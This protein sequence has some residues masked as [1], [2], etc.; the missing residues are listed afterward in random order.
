MKSLEILHEIGFSG[1]FY[2][3]ACSDALRIYDEVKREDYLSIES[4]ENAKS[5]IMVGKSASYSHL[6]MILSGMLHS[7]D[8]YLDSGI[9]EEIYLDTMSD[10]FIWAELYRRLEGKV[11]LRETGWLLLHI[12]L[13]LFRL[14][15]LQ[16]Q[17][18]DTPEEFRK[19]VKSD[20]VIQVHIPDIGP[21][22]RDECISSFRKAREFYQGNL[23]F[24]C[25]SWLLDPEL[26]R[27]LPENSN[28]LEFQRLFTI[29]YVDKSNP[30]CHQRVFEF[31]DKKDTSLQRNILRE[32]ALGTVFGV[33]YGYFLSDG[34]I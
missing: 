22:D 11:G 32:E 23:P 19:E 1:A 8:D 31:S 27:V 5:R 29:F 6:V 10:A 24:I 17:L 15:R 21:L 30:Q 3:G 2:E 14:G 7:H 33:G 28:I 34:I 16:F 25:D 26:G 12:R 9:P 13:E 20:R 18:D 4:L